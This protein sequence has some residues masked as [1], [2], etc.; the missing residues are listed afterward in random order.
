MKD[1]FNEAVGSLK[2]MGFISATRQN[3]F[4]FKKNIFGKPKYYSTQ[5]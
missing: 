3:T 1:S 4:L 5:F 2:Y